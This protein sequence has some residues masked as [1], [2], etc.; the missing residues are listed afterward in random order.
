MKMNGI[1]TEHR[2]DF[3]KFE[4]GD[5]FEFYVGTNNFL[6][7]ILNKIDMNNNELHFVTSD[8]PI[9]VGLSNSGFVVRYKNTYNYNGF[10]RLRPTYKE[11]DDF[12]FKTNDY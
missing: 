5:A 11:E 10:R 3:A 1:I 2:I 6:N 12:N 7:G 4:I 8:E 9:I